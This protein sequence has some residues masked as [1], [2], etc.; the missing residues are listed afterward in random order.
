MP[1]LIKD[2]ELLEEYSG[3]WEKVSK[4]IKKLFDSDSVNNQKYFKAKI[5]PYEGTININFHKIDPKRR[6]SL[7]LSISGI[8]SLCSENK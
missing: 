5:K 4:F 1:F 2:S 6:F 3:I 8:D 7:Y